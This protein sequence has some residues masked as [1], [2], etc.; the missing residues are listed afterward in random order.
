MMY[1]NDGWISNNKLIV[2]R[3]LGTTIK[4]DVWGKITDLMV[5]DGDQLT[6]RSINKRLRK[7]LANRENGLKGGRP[8][9]EK[10]PDD[11]KPKKPKS[12]TQKNPPLERE[13]ERESESEIKEK[14]KNARAI[15]ILKNQKQTE[16]DVLWMQN[17]SQIPDKTKLVDSFNDK[18][19]LEIAQG[20][21]EFEPEQLMPRFRAYVRQWVSNTREAKA[22][23]NNAPTPDSWESGKLPRKN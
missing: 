21:I 11:E 5:E 10:N 20:K 12:E 15:D 6:H 1:T 17:K 2:E 4:D 14:G 19:E 13:R 22:K 18:M 3:R 7:T 8:K 23:N 9:K 16:L